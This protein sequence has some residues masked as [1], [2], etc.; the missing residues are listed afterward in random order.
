MR[1]ELALATY[2][3]THFVAIPASVTY[4]LSSELHVLLQSARKGH[5]EAPTLATVFV[6]GELAKPEPIAQLV[7][8]LREAAPEL[9]CIIGCT[10][11]HQCL[12][13]RC[14]SCCLFAA[15]KQQSALFSGRIAVDADVCLL[16]ASSSLHGRTLSF[17]CMQLCI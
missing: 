3:S 12:F 14:R 13:N 6:S 8:R 17:R 10:V 1:P 16:R 9:T 7:D 2:W 5:S 11:R 15:C 4:R